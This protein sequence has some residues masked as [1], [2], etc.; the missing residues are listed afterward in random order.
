VMRDV[1]ES[2][3]CR[4]CGHPETEHYRYIRNGR[5]T[6]C[7]RACDPLRGRKEPI[8]AVQHDSYEAAMLEA[9]NHDFG[10]ADA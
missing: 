7:C 5:D 3:P 10:M 4:L 6:G 2:G 9:C 1:A 8:F